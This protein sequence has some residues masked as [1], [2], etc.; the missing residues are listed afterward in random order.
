MGQPPLFARSL[1]LDEARKP[2]QI[3]D[4]SKHQWRRVRAGICSPPNTEMTIKQIAELFHTDESQVRRLIR[5]FND[6][7]V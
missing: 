1:R 4:W 7:V 6:Q 3:R 5:D 2:K